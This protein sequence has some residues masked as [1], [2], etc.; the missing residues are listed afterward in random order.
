LDALGD[1][2]FSRLGKAEYPSLAMTRRPACPISG[3][4]TAQ[5][6]ATNWSPTTLRPTAQA[7]YI[8]PRTS[9]PGP[10]TNDKSRDAFQVLSQFELLGEPVSHT[11][12]AKTS[13]PTRK[14]KM[15]PTPWLKCKPMR[16]PQMPLASSPQTHN[17]SVLTG[18][19]N[20]D[21]DVIDRL[22]L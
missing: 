4:S 5:W 15:L 21:N 17:A 13:I 19:A 6:S 16:P 14:P 8:R 2:V 22:A 10:A 9:P 11:A 18:I 20:L 3:W 12:Q 1:D 7:T